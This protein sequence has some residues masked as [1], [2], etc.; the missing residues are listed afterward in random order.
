MI[1]REFIKRGIHTKVVMLGQRFEHMKVVH[2]APIPATN[3]SFGQCQ[4]GMLDNTIGVKELF[5]PKTITGWASTGRIVKGEQP[6]FQL[7]DAITA[8]RAGK[9]GGKHDI[10]G[11]IVI[12]KAD[13]C[14]TIG[15]PQCRLERFSQPQLLIGTGLDPVDHNFDGM[16]FIF[17]QRW[18]R[19]EIGDDT[20]DTGTDIALTFQLTEYM[21]MFTFASSY[22]RCQNHNL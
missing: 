2:A 20:V 11:V 8:F 15:E 14:Q 16:F 4:F 1:R 9:A 19:V 10:F 3:C 13:H 22:D 5:N 18:S 21:Q 17:F 12:H 7:I 6:W